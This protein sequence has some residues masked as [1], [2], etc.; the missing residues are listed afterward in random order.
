MKMNF[1]TAQRFPEKPKKYRAPEF[2]ED[3]VSFEIAPRKHNCFSSAAL[4]LILG[5]PKNISLDVIEIY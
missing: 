2:I 4:G 3:K 5:I 1:F